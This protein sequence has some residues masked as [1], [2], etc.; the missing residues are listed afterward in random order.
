[1][2]GQ[3]ANRTI[4]NPRSPAHHGFTLPIGA[5]TPQA[6]KTLDDAWTR[7]I[8][9]R[10]WALAAAGYGPAAIGRDEIVAGRPKPPVF[11][12]MSEFA[13]VC[14]L[15]ACRDPS[16]THGPFPDRVVRT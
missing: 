16:D 7:H 14:G 1:M 11:A 10:Q 9:P 4:D 15:C 13:H 6:W 5:E 2:L 3:E 8:N 12:S